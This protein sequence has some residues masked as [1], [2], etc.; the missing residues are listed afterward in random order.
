MVSNHH[1]S[2]KKGLRLFSVN[3]SSHD[4]TCSV[5]WWAVGP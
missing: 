2:K 4:H 5:G 3:F 1:Q